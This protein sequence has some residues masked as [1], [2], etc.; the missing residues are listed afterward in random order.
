M[1]TFKEAGEEE[2]RFRVTLEPDG[3]YRDW[4]NWIEGTRTLCKILRSNCVNEDSR[5][6]GEKLFRSSLY[7]LKANDPLE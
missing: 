5:D 1:K 2:S 4:S 3:V 6:W 7:S